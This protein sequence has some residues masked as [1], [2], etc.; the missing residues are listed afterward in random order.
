MVIRWADSAFAYYD[1]RMTGIY[2]DVEDGR[3][4]SD[5]CEK[6][7][8]EYTDETNFEEEL[9]YEGGS[10]HITYVNGML[11][12]FDA[13]EDAG[14]GC[15]FSHDN[16]DGIA[17]GEPVSLELPS[18]GQELL[19]EWMDTVSQRAT[20]SVEWTG[21]D[22]YVVIHW[23]NSASEAIEWRMNGTYADVEDGR[24]EVE[25]CDRY[26]IEA[27]EGS[28]YEEHENTTGDVHLTLVDGVLHWF[29]PQ[30]DTGADCMFEKMQ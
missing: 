15:M 29:D 3:I 8:V 24:I 17:P 4:V 1:W 7:Y 12:W 2:E 10:A 14:E 30:D 9:L 23:A 19:G 6:Y 20:M 27:E 18:E 26:R 13:E 11:Y 21:T 16:G 28:Y 25:M 22:F 5:D